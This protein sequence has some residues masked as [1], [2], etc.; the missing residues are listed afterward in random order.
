MKWRRPRCILQNLFAQLLSGSGWQRTPFCRSLGTSP[1]A[2]PKARTG[3]PQAPA[4]LLCLV[5]QLLFLCAPCPSR[6]WA[7]G[8]GSPPEEPLGLPGPQS[9]WGRHGCCL[10]ALL[11]QTRVTQRSQ[12]CD[13]DTEGETTYS[14]R[15]GGDSRREKNEAK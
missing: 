5:S 13:K 6:A 8:A 12:S 15:S 10:T 7:W 3:G 9:R 14:G 4:G 1:W 2:L 11:G